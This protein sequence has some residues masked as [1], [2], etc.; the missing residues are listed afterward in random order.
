MTARGNGSTGELRRPESAVP[1]TGKVVA[2]ELGVVQMPS[3]T[4]RRVDPTHVL[5]D[6]AAVAK[7][8][9]GAEMPLA[10]AS[11][12]SPAFRGYIDLYH[13]GRGLEG[14]AVDLKDTDRPLVLELIV[15]RTVIGRRTTSHYR[16]DISQ[17]VQK[18]VYPGFNFEPECFASLRTYFEVHGNAEILIRISG[19]NHYLASVGPA[20]TLSTVFAVGSLALGS[21]PA[22]SLTT[23][24]SQLLLGARE[25]LAMPLR[26][27]D[28]QLAGFIEVMAIDE[29]VIWFSGWMKTNP[30]LDH[31]AVVVDR[32]KAP[33][34]LT[35]VPYHRSDLEAGSHGVIGALLTDWRPSS[36]SEPIV[37]FGPDGARH[38][39]GLLPLQ[40]R[41]FPEFAQE[42]ARVCNR[43][44]RNL[45][46]DL[47]AQFESLASHGVASHPSVRAAVDKVLVLPGFGAFVNGWV[48]SP[49][50]KVRSLAIRFGRIVLECDP[51]SLHFKP[52]P[53][54]RNA[55]HGDSEAVARA[56]FCC[57]CRGRLEVG[58]LT[59]PILRVRFEDGASRDFPLN[60]AEI[61]RLGHSA[62]LNGLL[63]LYPAI[64]HE[65]FFAALA[66]S[67]RADLRA[68][69]T[70]LVP[71]RVV[72]SEQALIVVMP[73]DRHDCY[74]LFDNLRR[75]SA[76]SLGC[77]CGI[78]LV[79]GAE[80]SHGELISLF[81]ALAD[82][83]PNPCSLMFLDD[84]E[85]ALY[86]LPEILLLTQAERF[87][88]VAR[89]HFLTS[90]GW[91]ALREQLDAPP[92]LSFLQVADPTNPTLPGQRSSAAFVWSS[93]P[94]RAWLEN[95]PVL[96]GE[97][98]ESSLFPQNGQQPITVER[99]VEYSR[100]SVQSRLLTA[101]NQ[102][103]LA[104]AHE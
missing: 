1:Q 2:A 32:Q 87:G 82:R 3:P 42:F 102:D 47:S 77:S 8:V 74:L 17:L 48:L 5:L 4:M 59:D 13:E 21:A 95:A 43:P 61:H 80:Q 99:A 103:A 90:D 98:I 85:L 68:A 28:H 23:L 36:L 40:I 10:L 84:A 60:G 78:V 63:D 44:E 24:L 97:H 93:E 67:I 33:A 58:D 38:L 50:L 86:A 20:P 41:T 9:A 69:W 53:D 73:Q 34:G 56:G 26:P 57:V 104:Q 15:G 35:V 12:E 29:R 16:H 64:E 11:A 14:W 25:L 94:F 49:I 30:V 89:G 75:H 66:R 92:R 52:R 76:S 62:S 65:L 22:F 101:I 100:L 39:K 71:R 79:G 37:Y 81:A 55:T 72:R 18:P 7:P 83:L 19:S 6:N 51:G 96:I 91:A 70:R 54:L 88:F 27:V 31:A 46:H 45:F